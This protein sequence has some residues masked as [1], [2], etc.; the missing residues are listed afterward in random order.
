MSPRINL[1]LIIAVLAV[2]VVRM[3]VFTVDER[4]HAVKFRIGEIVK[5][6]YEPGLHFK[7]PLVNNVAKYPKRIL[8]YEHSEEKFLTGEKK[9]LI[10]DYFVTWR[11]TDPAQ[12][13]RSVSGEEALAVERLQA[14]VKE[15][16]KAA[17][18]Q[19][20]VQEVVSAERAELM[21]E[22][23]TAAQERSP[24]LGIEIVD[25]R[26]KRIDLSDEVSESVYQRMRQERERVATQL[27]AEGEEQYQRIKAEADRQRTVILSEAY[28]DA[29]R[30]R[31]AGDAR[32]AEIYAHAYANDPEFY[33]FYRSMQAYRESIGRDQDVLVLKPDSDFFQFLQKQLGTSA[34]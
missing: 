20:T 6:D 31:G 14:I 17:I 30:T 9:N 13:Y 7:L 4:E 27:R 24:E 29:E 10:V 28:R 12:Y 2:I 8:T 18:S 15:G 22:M 33:S 26:V 19:R 11:I 3:S 34:K 1:L 25:V 21:A 32:A 5:M 16:I 23:L